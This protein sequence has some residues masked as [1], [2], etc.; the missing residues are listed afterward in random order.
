MCS[1]AFLFQVVLTCKT[2]WSK[3]PTV[4]IQNKSSAASLLPALAG[5]QQSFSVIVSMECPPQWTRIGCKDH[6]MIVRAIMC[7]NTSARK[8]NPSSPNSAIRNPTK[9]HHFTFSQ[10]LPLLCWALWVDQLMAEGFFA[11]CCCARDYAA[12]ACRHPSAK[13]SMPDTVRYFSKALLLEGSLLT[14]Q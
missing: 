12:R 2:C 7:L 8:K 13:M 5:A 6:T 11:K 4:S 10:H 9:S 1:S 14:F 3:Q